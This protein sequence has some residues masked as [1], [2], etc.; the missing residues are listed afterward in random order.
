M[1]C[2]HWLIAL[3][4]PGCDNLRMLTHAPFAYLFL[5]ARDFERALTFYRDTLEFT[6]M[7]HEPGQNAFFQTANGGP[8]LALY[9]GRADAVVMDRP[10]WWMAFNVIDLEAVCLRL[11]ERGVVVAPIEAVPGGRAAM[12]HDPDGNAIELHQPTR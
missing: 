9:P 12:L 7:Y 5:H 6:L 3:T 11:R 4:R 8:V 2:W 1:M 10:Y